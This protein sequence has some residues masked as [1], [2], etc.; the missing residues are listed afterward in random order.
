MDE[1]C[2]GWY[3]YLAKFLVLQASQSVQPRSL[4]LSNA[5]ASVPLVE[6]EAAKLVEAAGGS[7]E[8]FMS[9][10]N[11]RLPGGQPEALAA[12][13]EHAGT[14]WRGSSAIEG[15]EVDREVLQSI[16]CPALV[17]RGEHDFVTELCTA[18]WRALPLA[19]FVTIPGASH[20][21]LLEDPER[22]LA[23]LS[24]FLCAHDANTDDLRDDRC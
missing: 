18:P 4:T 16:A 7:I 20:H 8:A 22:Y 15:L 19:Q 1:N 17:I 2:D 11:C 3:A 5:P 6:T 10:H 14:T 9:K 23:E 24:A 12:A 13:Y 21:T